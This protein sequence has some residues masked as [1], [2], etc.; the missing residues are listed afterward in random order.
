VD[1]PKGVFESELEVASFDKKEVE[2][3]AIVEEAPL[4]Q[5]LNNNSY[6]ALYNG[7]WQKSKGF[8]CRIENLRENPALVATTSA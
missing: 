5:W 3:A 1:C 2:I 7:L 4:R 8:G 6:E